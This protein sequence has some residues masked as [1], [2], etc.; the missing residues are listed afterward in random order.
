MIIESFQLGPLRTALI[1][2]AS[3]DSPALMSNGGCSLFCRL[4]ST[5]ATDGNLP[6]DACDMKLSR[7]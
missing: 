2:L 7:V 5:N 6:E 1:T 3:S 4:K